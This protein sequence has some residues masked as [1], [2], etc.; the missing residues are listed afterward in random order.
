[1]A[2][3]FNVSRAAICNLF[4]HRHEV[5]ARSGENPLAKH[6]KKK[7]NSQAKA[8]PAAKRQK[9]AQSESDVAAQ[10]SRSPG[11]GVS[12]S[13]VTTQ[14]SDRGGRTSSRSPTGTLNVMATA[15]LQLLLSALSDRT[16]SLQDFKRNSDR[17][18]WLIL[19]EALAHVPVKEIYW[20]SDEAK[21]AS[22]R[23][24]AESPACAISMEPRTINATP[25]LDI[26]QL[27]EPNQPSGIATVSTAPTERSSLTV[28]IA[29]TDLPKSLR[30]YNV[31][32][33]NVVAASGE[34][35]CATIERLLSQ[36][37][38]AEG[39][40]TVVALFS[41]SEVVAMVQCKYPMAK[42]VTARIDSTIT[43]RRVASTPVDLI[44]HRV[45]QAYSAETT[46]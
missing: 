6:P 38:V 17:V 41:S 11:I 23:Y 3:E 10:S 19:E 44:L 18:L 13:N 30:G 14:S 35:V 34:A 32:L 9:R 20:E 40:V 33:L 46:S 16:R 12:E 42:I 2:K 5:L 43:R 15:A 1:L 4:K 45:R 24:E 31:F 28:E 26:F 25:M 29:D 39:C 7:K 27:I 21:P 36:F 22:P 8:G 37:D